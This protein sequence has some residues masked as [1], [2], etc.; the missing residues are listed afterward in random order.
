M[1][2]SSTLN[3]I[4]VLLVEDS[5][6]VALQ[7][8][9]YLK[10]AKES[11]FALTSVLT[12][13]DGLKE[14]D[15]GAFDVILLDLGLPDSDGMDT[16]TRMH[17]HAPEIPTIVFTGVSDEEL[18]L[19]ALRRGK[20]ESRALNMMRRRPASCSNRS[21]SSTA[22]PPAR[23]SSSRATTVATSSQPA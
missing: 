14:V 8:R 23:L 17:R 7:I 4:Q 9:E 10:A 11:R 12:L 2:D 13:A 1:N 19:E 6:A 3:A 15:A 21:R 20:Y 5:K 22:V 16:F 18:A